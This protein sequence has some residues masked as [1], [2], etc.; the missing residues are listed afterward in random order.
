MKKILIVGD[1]NS[2]IISENYISYLANLNGYDFDILS[3]KKIKII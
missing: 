3:F 2:P 1:G